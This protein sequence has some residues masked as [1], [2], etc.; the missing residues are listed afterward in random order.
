MIPADLLGTHVRNRADQ[1]LSRRTDGQCLP[2]LPCRP[3]NTEVQ[4]LGL[5]I[6]R[7]EDV[8]RL[9]ITVDDATV[10]GMLN[11]VANP[12]HQLEHAAGVELVHLRVIVE[13]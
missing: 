11:R 12:G 6:G 2:V 1:V 5:T 13:G 7:H 4:H 3:C 8:T 10:V 9:E